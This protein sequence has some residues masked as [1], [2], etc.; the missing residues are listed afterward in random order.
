MSH[1]KKYLNSPRI[2]SK[3]Q[4]SCSPTEHKLEKRTTDFS[5]RIN[6]QKC[7]SNNFNES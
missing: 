6:K 5:K 3:G 2:V 1:E 4:T 7:V